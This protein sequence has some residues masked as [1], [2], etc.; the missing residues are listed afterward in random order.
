MEKAGRARD[1]SPPLA[2]PPPTIPQ[3]VKVEQVDLPK[4]SII[5]RPGFGTSGK[6]VSLLANHFKVSIGN[7]DETFYQYSVKCSTLLFFKFIL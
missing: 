2:P 1:N 5:K 4:R 6:R 3:N 7:P